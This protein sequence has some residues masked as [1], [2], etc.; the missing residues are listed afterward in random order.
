MN[1]YSSVTTW[2]GEPEWE[3]QV[4]VDGFSTIELATE[5]GRKVKRMKQSPDE[6]YLVQIYVEAKT[7]K[8]KQH[9]VKVSKIKQGSRD[10]LIVDADAFEQMDIRIKDFPGIQGLDSGFESLAY[11]VQDEQ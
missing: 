9:Q 7:N 2:Q 5:F 3:I 10:K 11:G 1:T 4:T 8:I 6:N